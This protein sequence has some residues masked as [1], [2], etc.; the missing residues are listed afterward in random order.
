M[1]SCLTQEPVLSEVF[2][3]PQ[4]GGVYQVLGV[5]GPEQALQS[6][7]VTVVPVLYVDA[8]PGIFPPP[9]LSAIAQRGEGVGGHHGKRWSVVLTAQSVL[10]VFD[11]VEAVQLN[12]IFSHLSPHLYSAIK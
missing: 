9:H 10:F 2:V 11:V 5:V 1:S 4:V 3:M 7:E 8:A 6:G 12:P